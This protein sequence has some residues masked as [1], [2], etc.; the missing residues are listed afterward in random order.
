MT[1][2]S[3]LAA[4]VRLATPALTREQPATFAPNSDRA[5]TTLVGPMEMTLGAASPACRAV[6]VRAVW[7]ALPG[8]DATRGPLVVELS[9]VFDWSDGTVRLSG[10]IASRA[11]PDRG[12]AGEE[13]RLAAAR[14]LRLTRREAEVA[15]LLA[16]G[17]SNAD[18]AVTLGIS[19]HTARRHTES[20]MLKLRARTRA[21]VGPILHGVRPMASTMAVPYGDVELFRRP[22]KD[23]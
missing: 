11:A 23:R 7:G 4:G 6:T 14:R 15:A 17:G 16:G 12:P 20:V 2:H 18:I 5:P 22:L 8:Q 19:P 10:M 9:G 21:Q 13:R 1:P 3:R